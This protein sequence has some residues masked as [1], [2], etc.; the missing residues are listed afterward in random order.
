LTELSGERVVLRPLRE[1]DAS[2][3]H[4]IASTFEVAR[5]WGRPEDEFPLA[6]DPGATR[7]VILADREIVGLIQ[8]GEEE[9]PDFRHAW[10]DVFVDPAH[11]GRGLGTDAVRTLF[12]HLVAEHGHHRVTIDPALENAA[13]IR[14]YEKAGF[15]PVG[16]LRSAWRDL[17]GRWRDVLLME[18][19]RL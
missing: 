18:Q 12:E 8:Y 4:A 7:F 11:H 10:I 19:V 9:E 1:S 17:E 5:W 16:T 13:A 14:S 3:V 6:D 2:R 15:R